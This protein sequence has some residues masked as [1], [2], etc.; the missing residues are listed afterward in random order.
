MLLGGL[1]Y[2]EGGQWVADLG[3]REG[4][5]RDW[6]RG[7]RVE[8]CYRYVLH[9]KI[10]IIN[11]IPFKKKELMIINTLGSSKT[12][13]ELRTSEQQ[14]FACFQFSERSFLHGLS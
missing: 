4:G 12:A 1:L 14:H 8:T 13:A 7:E 5:G 10:T 11:Q 6:G 2:S 3:K 9:E